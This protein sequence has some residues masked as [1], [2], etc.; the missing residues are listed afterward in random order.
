M[1]LNYQVFSN[2]SLLVFIWGDCFACRN[3]VFF[4]ANVSKWRRWVANPWGKFSCWER[5]EWNLMKIKCCKDK[6]CVFFSGKNCIS[7]S[8]MKTHEE[9]LTFW[10]IV[11]DSL[12]HEEQKYDRFSLSNFLKNFNQ[13]RFRFGVIPL[14]QMRLNARH[15]WSGIERI[16]RRR[17]KL[18]IHFQTVRKG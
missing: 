16:K 5:H 10:L 17:K 3:C 6:F 7:S 12:V 2:K 4:L 11:T 1:Q 15:P 14:T 18:I 9:L 13:A 8:F